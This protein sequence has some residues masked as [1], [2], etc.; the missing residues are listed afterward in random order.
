MD[1]RGEDV[2]DRVEQ[3]FGLFSQILIHTSVDVEKT[4]KWMRYIDQRQ[5]VFDDSIS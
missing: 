5:G 1:S 4:L 2:E 3:L